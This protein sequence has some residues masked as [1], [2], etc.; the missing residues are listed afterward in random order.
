MGVRAIAPSE[1]ESS[2]R[3]G[4]ELVL[5]DVRE[6]LELAI[7]RIEGSRHLQLSEFPLRARELDPARPTVCI[8]HHG[9]RSAIAAAALAALGFERV[10]NLSGGIDRWAEEIDPRMARY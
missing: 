6:T 3:R 10:F 4:E 2:L 5:V 7:C 1:L 8:C 9:I